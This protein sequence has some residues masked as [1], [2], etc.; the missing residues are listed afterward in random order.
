MKCTTCKG[1]GKSKYGYNQPC[2]H[3]DGTGITEPLT[4]EERYCQL[5]TEEKA[6]WLSDVLYACMRC[7]DMNGKGYCPFGKCITEKED[8]LVWL[9]EE[10]KE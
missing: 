8:A 1:T 2:N 3:C 9:K 5:S 4:N 7:G 6:K 10:H